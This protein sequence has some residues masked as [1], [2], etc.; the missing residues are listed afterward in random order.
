MKFVENDKKLG[1]KFIKNKKLNVKFSKKI[2]KLGIK[3]KIILGI[4]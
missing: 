3:R 4:K 2:K 1:I